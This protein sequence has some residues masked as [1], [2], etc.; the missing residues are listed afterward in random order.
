MLIV[1]WVAG[2]MRALILSRTNASSAGL[3]TSNL[4]AVPAHKMVGF[5]AGV[6]LGK[7]AQ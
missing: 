7:A 4:I 1:R 2:L 6:E 3:L 5:T